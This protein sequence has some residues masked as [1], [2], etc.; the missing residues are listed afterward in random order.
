MGWIVVCD[1]VPKKGGVWETSKNPML[2]IRYCEM[3]DGIGYLAVRYAKA[4]YVF[5]G[6]PKRIFEVL[7]RH[8]GAS[9]YLRQQ[10]RN[11]FPC[12]DVKTYTDL[13]PFHSEDESGMKLKAEILAAKRLAES[14]P[15]APNDF[16]WTLF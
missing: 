16:Q 11:R 5:E 14:Q 1:Q 15:K 7:G 6:V 12:V 2:G 3:E 9:M 13:Q 10:V 8:R 4:R